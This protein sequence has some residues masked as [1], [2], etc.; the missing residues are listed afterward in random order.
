MVDVHDS[1][2]IVEPDL[3]QS[4]CLWD[5]LEYRLLAAEVDLIFADALA[6]VRIDGEPTVTATRISG[7]STRTPLRESG[8]AAPRRSPNPEVGATQRSPPHREEGR[9]A[10]NHRRQVMSH[11]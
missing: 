9:S 6:P 3:P 10:E 1:T 11:A 5:A 4:E 8:T 7:G 2:L